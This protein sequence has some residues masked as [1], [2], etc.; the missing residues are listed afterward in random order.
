M[1]SVL[2]SVVDLNRLCLDPDPGSIVS[3]VPDP[4]LDSNRIRISSD[5]DPT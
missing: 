2:S 4:A 3:S 1:L 5:P